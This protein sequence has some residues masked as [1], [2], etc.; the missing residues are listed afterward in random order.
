MQLNRITPLILTYNEAPNLKRTLAALSWAQHIVVIDSYS[1]DATLDILSHYPNV[2]IYKRPF[3]SFAQQCN[4][5]LT[6]ISTEW[7]LS[8]DADYLVSTAF[9]SEIQAL[10]E[11]ISSDG[12]KIPLRYCVFGYPLRGTLLPPR[13]I[14]YR[15]IKAHYFQD[16]HAHRVQ[17]DG[18]V[19]SLHSPIGHDDR[20][21][22]SHWLWAQNR[23]AALEVK[24]LSITPNHQLGLADKIRKTKILAPFFVLFYCLIFKGS[25]LDGWCGWYYAFQRMLAEILLALKLIEKDF[26]E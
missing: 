25:V 15:T 6:H 18:S 8:L 5:G 12:F 26:L 2:T 17:I 21:P 7:T 9:I 4:F 16:G 22:L 14:L 11:P 20:K 1:T 10:S 23:Y 13:T 3:D 24:K 19:A